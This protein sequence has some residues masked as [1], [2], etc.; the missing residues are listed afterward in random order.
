MADKEDLNLG[1]HIKGGFVLLV[2]YASSTR[3]KGGD[4]R[5]ANLCFL[6]L[7]PVI[8]AEENMTGKQSKK[9]KSGGNLSR[10]CYY[11]LLHCTPQPFLPYRLTK[12]LYRS[13]LFKKT[14]LV[15]IRNREKVQCL[16]GQ[17]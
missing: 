3:G 10:R 7:P 17:A 5:Q 14:Q 2:A 13:G 12:L 11:R 6:Q 8:N 15:V 9:Q 4:K 16:Q 1:P